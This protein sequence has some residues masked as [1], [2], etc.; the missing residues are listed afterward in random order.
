MSNQI[1][2]GD[3]SRTAILRGINSLANAVS[4]AGTQGRNVILGR[5]IRRADDHEGRRHGGEGDQPEGPDR[6]PG[7]R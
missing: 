4:D 6:E 5:T 1:T 7:P 2:Y 3:D